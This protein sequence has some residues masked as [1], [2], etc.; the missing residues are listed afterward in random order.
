MQRAFEE[1]GAPPNRIAVTFSVPPLDPTNFRYCRSLGGGSLW[2]LGPY[3]VSVGRVFFARPLETIA[4]HIL[5][6]GGEENV[7][8]AFSVLATYP[9]GRCVVGHFGFD[10]AYRNHLDILSNDVSLE[11][12]RAFTLPAEMENDI[13]VTH[14]AATNVLKAPAANAFRPFF[15]SVLASIEANDWAHFTSDLLTDAR[16]LQRL[17]DAAG[18]V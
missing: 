11:A 9:E 7:E 15:D 8:T 4:S 2:D 12:D 6:F 1:A 16:A 14:P 17:R 3:A 18:A 10:T 5:S 13:R